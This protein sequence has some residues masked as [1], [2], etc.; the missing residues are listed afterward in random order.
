M[1][2][3]WWHG[4]RW[5]LALGSI[6][7]T[8]VA[9]I[10]LA[11]TVLVAIIYFYNND[12]KSR[13]SEL[14]MSR[15]QQLGQ[16]FMNVA[17]DTDSAR[18]ARASY[19]VFPARVT[20]VPGQQ[21]LVAV[22]NRNNKIV[23]PGAQVRQQYKLL[24]QFFS[25]LVG[26]HQQA[27]ARQAIASAQQGHS[28]SG[29]I[30]RGL[31]PQPFFAQPIFTREDLE[32]P[33]A[34]VGVLII[35]PSTV[36]EETLPPF[37]MAVGS[38]VLIASFFIAVVAA[39]AAILFSRTIT[40]PL[41]RLTVATRKMATGDY[42]IRVQTEAQ[43]ELGELAKTFNEMAAQL[44]RDVEELY[45]QEAW[46]REL[47]MNIT[48]DLATPLTAIAGL[49]EALVDGVNQTRDDY[50]AT[51]HIIVRETL[52]LRRLVKD[53]HMM[54]KV[55]AGALHPQRKGVRL[56]TLVDESLAVL[57]PEFERANVEPC[58]A[59]PYDLPTVPADADMLSR[60]L[61]NLCDNALHHT[62]SGGSVTIEAHPVG[63]ELA[64]SVTDTG[65]GIPPDAL[66]RI[67]ERFYRVDG[68]RQSRIGGSGLGLAIVR[69]IVEAHGGRVWAENA[70]GAGARI[71]FTL[72]LQEA[73]QPSLS[74]AVTKPLSR[75]AHHAS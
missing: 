25:Q 47:I 33:D 56:A 21:Y 75:L 63:Q 28:A 37:V 66:P 64:I 42:T 20:D 23:Y 49:G 4:I 39:T 3:R 38:V 17:A 14:A 74:D 60:V 59:I 73:G 50:E 34:V 16:S 61:A 13:M 35:L 22:L 18:L 43:G 7:M 53:L 30:G 71:I 8:M 6:V 2:M 27:S 65:R 72:P 55:E 45:K 41:T 58:N 40:R 12:Q 31:F 57:V 29:E 32:T 9:T 68:A 52:R 10:L 48:H 26:A 1:R 67:F 46:R 51:G 70:A 24:P 11:M 19:T 62:P 5:R 54:A 36:V 44:H 15:A 69:A